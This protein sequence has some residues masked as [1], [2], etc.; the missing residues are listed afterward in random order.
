M[1]ILIL[2]LVD[3][4]VNYTFKYGLMFEVKT[5]F[6]SQSYSKYYKFSNDQVQEF[7]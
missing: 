2:V 3:K 4:F 5:T 7:C 6:K 1:E